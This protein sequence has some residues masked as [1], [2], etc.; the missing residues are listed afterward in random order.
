MS[1][2]CDLYATILGIRSP[3]HVTDVKVQTKKEE[4]AVSIECR[5][6]KQHQCPSCGRSCP[7]YDTRQRVWRHLDTCQ[8]KTFLLVDVPRVKCEEHGVL[9]I[10]TPWAEPGSGFT[11]LFECLVIDWLKVASIAAVARLMRMSW[12]EVDGVMQRAVRRGLARRE[13]KP[14]TRVAVDETSYQK[15]HEYVTVT[16]DLESGDVLFVADDRKSESLDEFWGWLG[17][18]RIAGLK[19]VAMDMS[20]PYMMS[21][22]AHVPQAEQVICFDRFHVAK[23]LNEAVDKVRKQEH[24]E[25]TSRGDDTLKRTKYLLLENRENMTRESRRRFDELMTSSLKCGR[26]WALKDAAR[27]MW[28][29]TSRTWAEKNWKKWLARAAR[30]RLEPMKRAAG[31]L[32]KHL[33]GIINAILLRTTN[34]AAESA[35][36]RIQQI[37]RRACGYRNRER[38]RNAIYFH[39]GGLNLYPVASATHTNS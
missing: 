24:R 36:A 18:E 5:P 25:L 10:E 2:N 28:D 33:W 14:V 13:V 20:A 30:C 34:G 17:P 38:F 35:N 31:T 29:Y 16:T 7:G 22:R 9:Q 26:A 27:W 6:S 39:L 32:K 8:F 12:D 23:I 19:A 15:R 21:T 1:D 3:W 37:K 11:A 4:I